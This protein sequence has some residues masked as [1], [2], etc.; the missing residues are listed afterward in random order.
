MGAL[1]LMGL[2]GLVLFPNDLR[3]LRWV[4]GPEGLDGVEAFFSFWGDFLQFNLAWALVLLG[5][6]ALRKDR[7]LRRAAL[8]FFLA[9]ALSGISARVVKFSSGRARPDRVEKEELHW[10]TFRGPSASPKFHGYFSGH[11]A[12]S[13]GSAVALVVVLPRVGWVALGFAAFVGWARLY[14]NHHF[15]SDVAHGA[16]W[17]TMW[18]CLVGLGVARVRRREKDSAGV[19]EPGGADGIPE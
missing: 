17:G 1:V 5:V 4:Q 14:G 6:A 10:V 13:F 19:D 15:P 12:A 7:W 11:T 9:G 18:G 8:V 2:S 16:I 3:W